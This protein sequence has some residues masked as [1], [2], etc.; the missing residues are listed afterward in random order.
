[1]KYFCNLINIGLLGLF[2][3]SASASQCDC[4]RPLGYEK[5]RVDI[6][7]NESFST[8][9]AIYMR[10]SLQK[11]MEQLRPLPI[12]VGRIGVPGYK[13]ITTFDVVIFYSPRDSLQYINALN[14]SFMQQD[15]GLPIVSLNTTSYPYI[16]SCTCN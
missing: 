10:K 6:M 12:Y 5:I 11:V 15:T 7:C 4:I 16:E 8:V 3:M 13:F 9:K 2:F 1:M 14:T